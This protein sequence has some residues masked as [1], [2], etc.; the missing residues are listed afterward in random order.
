[1]DGGDVA[2]SLEAAHDRL[3]LSFHCASR[4]VP[5]GS[6]QDWCLSALETHLPFDSAFWSRTGIE[7]GVARLYSNHRYRL[8]P[9]LVD[10][11]QTFQDHDVIGKM[12]LASPGQ[13][14][15][16]SSRD[17]VTDRDLLEQIVERFGIE[18]VMATCLVDPL[19]SLI[20]VVALIR[21]A[22]G[23]RFSE[24]ERRLMQR[25]MPHLIESYSANRVIHL[26]EARQPSTRF[27]YVTAA[28]DGE[29]LLH[30]ASREFSRMLNAE[31]PTWCGPRLPPALAKLL[32][33]G[34][35]AIFQGER[36]VVH[37]EPVNELIWIRAR[38]KQTS[39]EL[40]PREIEVALLAAA[41]RSNK[42]I[43]Q[44]LGVSP[45]TVRNQLAGIYS[46]LGVGARAELANWLREMDYGEPHRFVNGAAVGTVRGTQSISR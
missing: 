15:N 23:P 46:K 32:P 30:V 27:D 17:V 38:T 19:T 42:H 6:F 9:A 4:E 33:G 40:S 41:G 8:P 10:A 13:T 20:S 36:I 7:D 37:L 21:G 16:L 39:V 44:T 34:K 25:V 18:H 28:C 26:M 1:M 35:H 2:A 45:F 5:V 31:W 29:A 11:W 24:A 12:A 14:I 22:K 3:V 43:A